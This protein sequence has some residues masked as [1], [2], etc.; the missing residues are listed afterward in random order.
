MDDHIR[1]HV[2]EQLTARELEIVDLIARG[3][4][5]QEISD[6]LLITFETVKW[7]LKQI[8]GKLY[9]SNRAQ[10]VAVVHAARVR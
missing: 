8:Y 7:Y 3:K 9:V 1:P 5:N 6:H 2:V 4:T 10:A